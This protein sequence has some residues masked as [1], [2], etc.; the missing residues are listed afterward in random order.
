MLG[1]YSLFEKASHNHQ[2]NIE[3]RIIQ[4]AT[5]KEMVQFHEFAV[6]EISAYKSQVA[7]VCL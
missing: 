3:H 1:E 4:L 7:F 5:I 2:M 6:T